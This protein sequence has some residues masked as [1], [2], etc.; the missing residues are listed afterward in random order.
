MFSVDFLKGYL[1]IFQINN[2]THLKN[3][4]VF[5]QSLIKSFSILKNKIQ[6][7]LSWFMMKCILYLVIVKSELSLEQNKLCLISVFKIH[8]LIAKPNHMMFFSEIK[9]EGIK[10]VKATKYFKYFSI[11][12]KHPNLLTK[13][14]K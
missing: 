5:F 12:N 2:H 13:I 7:V 8:S 3:M 6:I 9:R 11:N 1:N 10:N 4:D 14:V